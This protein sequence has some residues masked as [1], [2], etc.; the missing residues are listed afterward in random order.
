[1]ANKSPVLSH[2]YDPVEAEKPG[3]FQARCK[4]C[5][6]TPV[7]VRMKGKTTSNLL[8]HLKVGLASIIQ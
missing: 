5:T 8:T 6:T 7:N 4:H 2:F 1:M 3:T